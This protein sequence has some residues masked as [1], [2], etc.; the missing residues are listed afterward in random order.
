MITPNLYIGIHLYWFSGKNLPAYEGDIIG[1]GSIP[2][3]A[4][5]TGRGNG[6][7]L[8]YCLENSWSHRGSG[9]T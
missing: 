4:R 5:S 2:G 7:P 6:N 8:Q 9:M 1:A 3:L